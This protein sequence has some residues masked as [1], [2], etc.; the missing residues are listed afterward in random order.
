MLLGSLC[1]FELWNSARGR[2]DHDCRAPVALIFH[3]GGAG[4]A[5]TS[6][7]SPSELKIQAVRDIF[8]ELRREAA[9]GGLRCTD[10]RDGTG[11]ERDQAW[12]PAWGMRGFQLDVAVVRKA[13]EAAYSFVACEGLCAARNRVGWPAVSPWARHFPA[14]WPKGNFQFQYY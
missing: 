1:D 12:A 10:T 5:G 3:S 14:L 6:S 8:N 9:I 4:L 2:A 7:R 11:H 13:L